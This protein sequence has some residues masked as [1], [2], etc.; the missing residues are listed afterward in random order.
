MA[1]AS[2][3]DP[4]FAGLLNFAGTAREAWHYYRLRPLHLI[5]LY[6]VTYLVAA[7]ILF[8]FSRPE[9]AQLGQVL[10]GVTLGLVL[11]IGGSIVTAL[12]LVVMHDASVGRS[13][14][15][16]QAAA[17]L[18][19][20]WKEVIAA[21]LLACVVTLLVTT[22]LR[23]LLVTPLAVLS[24]F[25]L[26]SIPPLL[27]GP[28]IVVHAVVLERLSLVEAWHRTRALMSGNWRRLVSY[29]FLLALVVGVLV[30]FIGS[31][32][33]AVFRG[34]NVALAALNALTSGLLIPYVVAF[35]L[36]GFLDVRAQQGPSGAA[37][38]GA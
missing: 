38:A 21:A 8:T 27:F 13:T 23:I 15:L 3:D 11:P 5:A 16:R 35:L 2:R 10:V 29:W 18:T 9:A 31:A 22:L 6:T 12:A 34:N 30:I 28:P 17:H 1:S 7:L 32:L 33:V 36:V 4:P 37:Q 19:G 24:F 14:K 26:T 20:A 25:L